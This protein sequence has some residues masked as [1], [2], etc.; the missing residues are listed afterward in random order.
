MKFRIKIIILLL[1]ATF[2]FFNIFA[3]FSWK[4]LLSFVGFGTSTFRFRFLQKEEVFGDIVPDFSTNIEE[5]QSTSTSTSTMTSS[6]T[7]RDK[8]L[9]PLNLHDY[10]NNVTSHETLLASTYL[11]DSF[12]GKL[13]NKYED[14]AGK[15]PILMLTHEKRDL[16]TFSSLKTTFFFFFILIN[17]YIV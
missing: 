7:S 12:C 13:F 4:F 2:I 14:I 10:H 6:S 17:Y 16:E 15:L 9:V 3:F 5:I 11:T 1:V 8:T